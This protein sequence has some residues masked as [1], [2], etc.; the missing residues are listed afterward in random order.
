MSVNLPPVFRHFYDEQMIKHPG[1]TGLIHDG[2]KQLDIFKESDV[3]LSKDYIISVG[4][5]EFKAPKGTVQLTNE[6]IAARSLNITSPKAILRGDRRPLNIVLLSDSKI[7][8]KEV[9]ISNVVFNILE[10]AK[11]KITSDIPTPFYVNAHIVF[12]T[13]EAGIVK[14]LH[15]SDL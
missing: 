8:C 6:L 15:R 14:E 9:E 12:F 13:L 10:G 2:T 11:L 7:D 4:D 3:D 1:S 5:L